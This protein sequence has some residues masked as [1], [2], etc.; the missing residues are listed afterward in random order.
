MYVHRYVL[1]TQNQ[2]ILGTPLYQLA[3]SPV[4][5]RDKLHLSNANIQTYW[6]PALQK[7]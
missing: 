4:L 5:D 2:L 1:Q 6:Q 7:I 3:N